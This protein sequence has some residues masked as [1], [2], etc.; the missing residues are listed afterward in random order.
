MSNIRERGY[1]GVIGWPPCFLKNNFNPKTGST[2]KTM[3]TIAQ[4]LA[5]V[6]DRINN[7]VTTAGRPAGSVSLLAVSKTHSA[8]LIQA[9]IDAGQRAFGESYA[10]EAIPKMAQLANPTLVWHF[11]GPIQSNKTADIAQ[12]FAWVDSVDRIKIA[13]RL[14]AQRPASLPPLQVCIQVN[15]SGESSKSGVSAAG[16]PELAHAIDELPHLQLRGLMAIP[17]P[18]DDPAQQRQAFAQLR[19]LYEQL[20]ASGFKLDTLS[21]GMTDDMEAAIAEG[22]TIVRIGTAIF[23]ARLS[24]QRG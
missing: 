19:H 2:H 7:A 10:Q 3:T 20:N 21:M 18:T 4:R 22:A 24:P 5:Q 14:S 6:H 15:I 17:A 16:L 1:F 23:G 13:Q 12:H 11:I 9:A 8:E